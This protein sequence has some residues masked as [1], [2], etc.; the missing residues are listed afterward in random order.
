MDKIDL[1]P[2]QAWQKH[3]SVTDKVAFELNLKAS[4]ARNITP[5]KAF[6]GKGE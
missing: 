3:L 6:G 4:S 5:T 2:L 1:P